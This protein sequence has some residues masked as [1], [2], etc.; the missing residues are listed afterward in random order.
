MSFHHS[1]QIVQSGLV[2]LLDAANTKSY[3]GSGTTW[4]DLS[5]NG[6]H[7]TLYNSP[8]F[9][10]SHITLDGLSQYMRTT[11]T[12]DLSSYDSVTVEIWYKTEVDTTYAQIFEH[13]DNWN[14]NDG[15]FGLYSH[16]NGSTYTKNTH[17]T[18]F[19][20]L[21]GGTSIARDYIYTIDTNWTCVDHIV[22]QIVDA[23]GRLTYT[24]GTLQAFSGATRPTTTN[25]TTYETLVND[26]M[27]F[28]ARGGASSFGNTSFSQ[29]KIYGKKLTQ[30]EITQNYNALKGR[31]GL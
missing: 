28:G 19:N 20:P 10:S 11:N 27:Y 5:G 29:I 17:H 23:T 21:A 2:L 25:T 18:N 1:P 26:Y 3:P 4:N 12:L 24:D 31:F 14:T 22:S 9:N 6:N 8:T 15:G 16:N 30:S 13:T 7:I